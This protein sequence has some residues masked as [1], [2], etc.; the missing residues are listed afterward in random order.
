M[1]ALSLD[2]CNLHY[3]YVIC[4]AL[5]SVCTEDFA[6]HLEGCLLCMLP[7]ATFA[8][9]VTDIGDFVMMATGR[10]LWAMLMCI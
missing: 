6:D 10:L 5:H 3:I 1:S 2:L 8:C 4:T 9:G 7:S